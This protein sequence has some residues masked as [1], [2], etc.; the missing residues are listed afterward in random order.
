MRTKKAGFELEAQT[1]IYEYNFDLTRL[2]FPHI[3]RYLGHIKSPLP[4]G[5][6]AG[7]HTLP[8][9]KKGAGKIIDFDLNFLHKNMV[10]H[11]KSCLCSHSKGSTV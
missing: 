8:S 3:I 10:A 4:L 6:G 1:F 7:V 2:N 11:P 5:R 9:Q